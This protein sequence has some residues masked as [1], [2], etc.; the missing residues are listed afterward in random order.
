MRGLL[1]KETAKLLELHENSVRALE[2]K[3]RLVAR[4]DCHGW[5]VFDL[6]DILTLKKERETLRD[7]PPCECGADHV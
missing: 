2:R 6:A 1:V 7:G 3:G 5:R 4:R